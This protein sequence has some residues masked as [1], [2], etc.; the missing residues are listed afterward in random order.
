[1]SDKNLQD[2][3]MAE[4][5]WEPRVNAAHIGV[6]AKQG[7]VSLTGHVETYSEKN[8]AEAAAWRVKGVKGI[9]QEIDVR[10][11]NSVKHTDEQIAE[12]ALSRLSWDVTVPKNSASV[13]VQEGWLT[14]TGE[15]EW[16]YEKNDAEYDVARLPGVT[17]VSN[18]ITLRPRVDTTDISNGIRT[19]LHRSW[20][21]DPDTIRVKADGGKVTLSGTANSWH[22]REV[23]GSTAWAAKGATSVQNDITVAF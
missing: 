20:F 21:F 23:A 3:V 13:K 15:V 18:Q 17:G 11:P 12:A 6:T 9:A 1:M 19:A 7:V 16:Q 10:L 4:L 2:N 22:D 8:A 14:L 5:N